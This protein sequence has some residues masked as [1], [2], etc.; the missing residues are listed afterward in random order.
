MSLSAC[1][2]KKTQSKR[3][4]ELSELKEDKRIHIL[5]DYG[6]KGISKISADS[7]S[8]KGGEI[9][10]SGNVVSEYTFK[11]ELKAEK[12][13]VEVNTDINVVE[14]ESTESDR[15]RPIPLWIIIVSACLFAIG[16]RNLLNRYLRIL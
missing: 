11:E 14:E 12:E 1:G 10:A 2:A 5:M 9:K 15:K 13:D 8:I 4:A 16:I 3:K 7:V 6:V